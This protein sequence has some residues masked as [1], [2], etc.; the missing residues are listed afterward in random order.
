LLADHFVNGGTAVG[1]GDHFGHF[2]GLQIHDRM[3]VRRER[4]AAYLLHLCVRGI[5]RQSG[6][7]VGL[8]L[9]LVGVFTLNGAGAEIGGNFL[10]SFFA[11]FLLRRGIGF[12]LLHRCFIDFLFR[13]VIGFLVLL[14]RLGFNCR[15]WRLLCAGDKNPRKRGLLV[16]G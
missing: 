13:L 15:R 3:M 7:G 8:F 5:S 4:G 16:V 14:I 12:L 10:H 1:I 11:G 2:A 9:Q 6:S